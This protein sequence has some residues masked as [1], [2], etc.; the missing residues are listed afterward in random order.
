Y[1]NRV[2]TGGS[3]AISYELTL[4]GTP[5]GAFPP[6]SGETTTV[7]FTVGSAVIASGQGGGKGKKGSNGGSACVGD[8]VLSPG[9][10]VTVENKTPTP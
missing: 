4:N 1:F 3:T 7:S 6:A 10:H 2:P 8:A 5:E 9:S